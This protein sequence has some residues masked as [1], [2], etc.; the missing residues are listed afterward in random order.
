MS[1]WWLITWTTH[2]S[3]LPG[4]P[5]GF[6]TWKGREHVPP[7]KRYANPG[8][9]TYDANDYAERH[10]QVQQI[11]APPVT[12]NVRQQEQVIAAFVGEVSKLSLLPAILSI[13]KN[14]VHFLAKFGPRPIRP[15]VGRL[16]AAATRALH[17]QGM[18]V[19]RLWS[20][21]CHMKSLDDPK[22]FENAFAYIRRHRD[23]GAL[24]HVWE[25]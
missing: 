4:D 21:N 16:K 7:P 6:Q 1:K 2:G 14:H 23:H 25:H 3:W 17:D 20:R 19:E 11:A 22:A 15:A 18:T 24:I 8:E 13:D 5:R 9:Q 10:Q 12:L